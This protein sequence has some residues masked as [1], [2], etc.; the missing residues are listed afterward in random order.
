MPVFALTLS[1]HLRADLFSFVEGLSLLFVLVSFICV[2][3]YTAKKVRAGKFLAPENAPLP[4]AMPH[5]AG[6]LFV[7][8]VFV[9]IFLQPSLYALL[10]LMGTMIVLAQNRRTARTQ[11]GFDRLKPSQALVVALLVFG[12]VELVETPLTQVSTWVLDACQVP[13][14]EQQSV[15]TFRQDNQAATI[16]W[17]MFQAVLLFPI[18][19][20]LFFRGFLLTFLK[21]Y[22]STGLAIVLSAGF[23]A[24]V[25]LNLAAFIPLW[26]LGIVLGLAYE[27]TGSLL[28]PVCIHACFN[29]AT[30][31]FMLMDKGNPS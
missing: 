12:A 11:Y 31:L 17:F 30:A 23:F 22:T 5:L 21:N 28:V 16:V 13:H 7:A 6:W 18:I 10:V 14:P 24:A 29:L 15:E 2:A 1:P 9:L 27:H 3:A 19:E 4:L 25:H 20:E 8:S 26:F